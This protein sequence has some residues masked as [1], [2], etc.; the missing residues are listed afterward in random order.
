MSVVEEQALLVSRENVVINVG[1]VTSNYD[2]SVVTTVSHFNL[3]PTTSDNPW[4]TILVRPPQ[5]GQPEA[6]EV[7]PISLTYEFNPLIVAE[8]PSPLEAF[9]RAVLIVDMVETKGELWQ[10]SGEGVVFTEQ[11][12]DGQV[13]VQTEIQ[14]QGK[15]LLLIIDQVGQETTDLAFRYTASCMKIKSEKAG[16]IKFYH[17]QDPKIKVRRGQG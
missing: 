16:K 1:L 11:S 6:V 2:D 17:S 15:R 12:I 5:P 14:N 7:E 13:R 8:Q 9:Q 3:T 4:K 10:F